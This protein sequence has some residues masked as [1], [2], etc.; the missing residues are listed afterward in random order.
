ME[1]VGTQSVADDI[2]ACILCDTALKGIEVIKKNEEGGV[3]R[4][5]KGRKQVDQPP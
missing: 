3:T 5:D 2:L 1:P 4:T